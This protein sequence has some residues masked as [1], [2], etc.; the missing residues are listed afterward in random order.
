MNPRSIRRIAIIGFGEA[1]GIFGERFRG[2]RIE[3]AVTDIL[4][5]ETA[6]EA[7]L[8]KARKAKVSAHEFY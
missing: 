2:G 6:R 3:V 1:G 4:L 5:R 8:E 7:M